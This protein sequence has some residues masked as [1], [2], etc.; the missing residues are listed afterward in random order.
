MAGRV[1]V[2][3]KRDPVP[4]LPLRG[5]LAMEWAGGGVGD[6]DCGRR[7]GGLEGSKGGARP[8]GTGTGLSRGLEP[9]NVG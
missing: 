5:L 4:Q 1:G 2:T 7:E 3:K 8:L 9:R 6:T